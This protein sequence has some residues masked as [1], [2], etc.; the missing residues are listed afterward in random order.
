MDP[1]TALRNAAQA[2]SEHDLDTARLYLDDI[3]NWINIG[4]YTPDGFHDV[5]DEYNSMEV[6]FAEYEEFHS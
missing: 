2:L 4:G 3:M 1:D 5:L 6:S